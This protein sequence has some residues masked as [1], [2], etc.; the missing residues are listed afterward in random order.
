[1]KQYQKRH[2]LRQ[3]GTYTKATHEKLRAGGHFDS[4][5]AHLMRSYAPA[6]AKK[7]STGAKGIASAALYAHSKQPRHYCFTPETRILTSDLRWLPVGELVVGDELWAVEEWPTDKHSRAYERAKVT[8]SFLSMKEC[9]RV[10]LDTDESFVCS[11]DHPWLATAPKSGRTRWIEAE[12]LIDRR[13]ESRSSKAGR[14][15]VRPFLPWK[16]EDS[17]EAGWLAGMFDG[18]GSLMALSSEWGRRTSGLSIAQVVGPTA[19]R[20]AA[21]VHSRGSFHAATV[22]R[23]GVQPR[24]ELRSNGGGMATTAAFL[25][26]I[27]PERL[28]SK[29]DIEG[30]LVRN[31]Y[32]ANVI[33]IEPVG[34]QQVQSLQTTSGTYIAEGFVVHNT[35]GPARWQPVSMVPWQQHMWAYGDCSS[36]ATGCFKMAGLPDPNGMGYRAGY[37]GTLCQHGKAV[38]SAQAGDLVFYGSGPPWTHVAVAVSSNR[39]VSHGSEGG[40][41]LVPLGYRGDQGQIRRYV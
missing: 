17:Y 26:R 40:P 22:E 34:T 35:Q 18:E 23:V 13:Y 9:V 4:Y 12:S 41:F 37:T 25:G 36:F 21:A 16:A 32:G 38:A 28:I 31:R 33:S 6:R 30:G 5:G 3:T 39:V 19:D 24:L 1:V 8:A 10:C 15:L 27:R 7:S 11:V 14:K 29:F 20:L 2:D